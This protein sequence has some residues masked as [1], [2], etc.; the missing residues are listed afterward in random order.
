MRSEDTVPAIGFGPTGLINA[1]D[2]TRKTLAEFQVPQPRGNRLLKAQA[3]IRDVNAGA[4]RVDKDD[5]AALE[6]LTDAQWTILEQYMI[7]RAIGKRG[8]VLSPVELFKLES[9]LSGADTENEDR[10]PLARNTQ[11]ELY[12]AANLVMGGVSTRLAEPD[13][14]FDYNGLE[15]GLAAKRVRSSKQ[16]VKRAKDAVRQIRNSGIPGFVALNVDVLLKAVGGNPTSTEQ[17]DD[18]LVA[19]K[20]I[21]GILS[22]HEGVVGSLVFARDAR[23]EFGDEKPSFSCST[24][25]HYKFYC[26]TDAEKIRAEEFWRNAEQRIDERLQTL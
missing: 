24:T 5:D 9:M 19:I 11:F 7:A 13:L 22:Q 14:R 1:A 17:L 16:L 12:V 2:W 21:N 23:W 3:L 8:R 26:G 18:R 4:I 25:H 15:V 6:R 10:N 20:Q